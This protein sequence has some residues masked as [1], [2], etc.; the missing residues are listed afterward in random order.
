[1]NCRGGLG[2]R[3]PAR[4]ALDGHQRGV[5]EEGH[6]AVLSRA[7]HS[8][9]SPSVSHFSLL[10]GA[11]VSSASIDRPC[12]RGDHRWDDQHRL[13]RQYVL[14][15]VSTWSLRKLTASSQR[16]SLRHSQ[17]RMVP[18]CRMSLLL[19]AWCRSTSKLIPFECVSVQT[20]V[21]PIRIWSFSRN[22]RLHTVRI[23]S[24]RFWRR[25]IRCSLYLRIR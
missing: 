18:E 13:L 1:M 10:S 16:G 20:V 14:H 2:H 24:S 4:R 8:A 23:V 9:P 15:R 7:S 21:Y 12:T 17:G 5:E 22:M 25:L 6:P 11:N 3:V 19:D